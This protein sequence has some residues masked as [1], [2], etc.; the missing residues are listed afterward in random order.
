MQPPQRQ[1]SR[2][3][4]E[5]RA[6]N[7]N[8][9]AVLTKNTPPN[10]NTARLLTKNRRAAPTQLTA[11]TPRAPAA[12]HSTT[13]G[14][15][16]ATTF[17]LRVVFATAIDSGAANSAS[18]APSSSISDARESTRKRVSDFCQASSWESRATMAFCH[19]FCGAS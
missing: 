2:R 16:F 15:G 4:R 13:G 1:H 12:P 17:F 11:S 9:R 19:P 5:N 14:A 7:A 10:A 3:V 18:Y 8:M 6:K